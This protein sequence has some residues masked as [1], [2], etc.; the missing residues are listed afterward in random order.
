MIAKNKTVTRV[1]IFDTYFLGFWA[2]EIALVLLNRA[3]R[4]II[5]AAALPLSH[6]PTMQNSFISNVRAPSRDALHLGMIMK[7]ATVLSPL[8][9]TV[10]RTSSCV[11][12]SYVARWR[13]ACQAMRVNGMI[14]WASL[15]ATAPSI[16]LQ[17]LLAMW[18]VQQHFQIL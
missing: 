18:M 5:S 16:S 1:L 17:R 7:A 2:L 8:E 15:T 6:I 13:Q 3:S 4:F 14:F 10:K 11:R 12:Q 9:A